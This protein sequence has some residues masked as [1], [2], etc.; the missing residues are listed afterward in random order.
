MEQLSLCI[1]YVSDNLQVH[2]EWLCFETLTD[3]SAETISSTLKNLIAS[4][5]LSVEDCRAQGYDGASNIRDTRG[6]VKTK[7]LSEYP[8]AV[9]SY[10]SGHNLNLIIK[11]ASS[12]HQWLVES[13][14]TLEPGV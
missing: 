12:S 4:H 11:D 10:C 14:E 1:R 5:G 7:I 3:T 13:I 2:E 9:F 6:G 8:L